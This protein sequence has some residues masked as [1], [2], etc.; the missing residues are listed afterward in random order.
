MGERLLTNLI[1]IAGGYYVVVKPILEKLGLQKSKAQEE[2]ENR[3]NDKQPLPDKWEPQDFNAW[4]IQS[5]Y[6][7]D[8]Y[9]NRMNQSLKYSGKGFKNGYWIAPLYT[10]LPNN[11]ADSIKDAD[12]YFV[13]PKTAWNIVDSKLRECPTKLCVAYTCKVYKDKYGVDLKTYLD[14]AAQGIHLFDESKEIMANLD[15]YIQNLPTGLFWRTP[16]KQ[17][18]LAA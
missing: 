12:G 17:L 15:K 10:T 11:I 4:Q 14:N 5:I 1:L 16:D 18:K 13:S 7:L 9:V 3:K 8:K 6:N 2:Q